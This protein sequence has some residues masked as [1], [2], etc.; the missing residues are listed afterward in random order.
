MT[1]NRLFALVGG[2]EKGPFEPGEIKVLIAEGKLLPDDCLRRENDSRWI[3]AGDVKGLVALFEE[4]KLGAR[5]LEALFEGAGGEPGA[6]TC[7][8]CGAVAEA[9]AVF[10]TDCGAALTA[11]P[12]A[13]YP[14]C[15]D[16]GA[17]LEPDASF[18]TA[19]GRRLAI[20]EAPVAEDVPSP[21]EVRPPQEEGYYYKP[22]FVKRLTGF[23]RRHK[24]STAAG[25]LVL[26]S[27]VV[28]SVAG[29]FDYADNGY[30][31]GSVLAFVGGGEGPAS[32]GPGIAERAGKRGSLKFRVVSAAGGGR[33]PRG[34][35]A[36]L[37]GESSRMADAFAGAAEG[38]VELEITVA[39]NGGV[40]KT[41]V[42]ASS[43]GDAALE[44]KVAS[45]LRACKLG[46]ADG[47]TV[48]VVRLYYKEEGA[49]KEPPG[50]ADKALRGRET[51]APSE[52]GGGAPCARVEVVDDEVD[53]EGCETMRDQVR[54]Y[55]E[56]RP[57]KPYL[58]DKRRSEMGNIYDAGDDY[59]FRVDN[60]RAELLLYFSWAPMSGPIGLTIADETGKV[61]FDRKLGKGPTLKIIGEGRYV[62][63]VYYVGAKYGGTWH[64]EYYV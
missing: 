27:A 59:T 4:A 18:C 25:A 3:R 47:I 36:D 43:Y 9:D 31:D 14:Q 52:P 32:G 2:S 20:A 11:A 19:C 54:R 5:G 49:G 58:S 56:R 24:F 62:V 13:A 50:S 46:P 21:A 29:A 8:R 22:T 15:P 30:V 12:M 7:P 6:V 1:Q 40:V 35:A 39:R 17:A 42:R 28:L 38:D 23:A 60:P 57:P 45:A 53:Y 37:E 16:C 55:L 64:C 48:A 26:V 41:A 61:L 34:I 33:T 51:T 10:C 63:T 44:K